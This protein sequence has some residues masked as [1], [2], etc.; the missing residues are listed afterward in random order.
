[1]R[2]ALRL[3]AACTPLRCLQLLL[4]QAQPRLWISLL[5]ETMRKQQKSGQRQQGQEAA[6]WQLCAPLCG[7]P[8][9]G[10]TR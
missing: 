9:S 3:Q 10:Q 5:Q 6:R 4:A 7:Q 1:M 8:W 2:A